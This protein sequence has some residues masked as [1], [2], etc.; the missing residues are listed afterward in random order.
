[1]QINFNYKITI[2]N[3]YF[4]LIAKIFN[5]VQKKNMHVIKKTQLNTNFDA[6]TNNKIVISL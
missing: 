2:T 1:M 3:Y 4:L 5:K 6:S